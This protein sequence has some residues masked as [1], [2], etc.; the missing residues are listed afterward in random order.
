VRGACIEPPC[1]VQNSLHVVPQ[2]TAKCSLYQEHCIQRLLVFALL[3]LP[4]LRASRRAASRMTLSRF[5]GYIGGIL[6]SGSLS[7]VVIR[8]DGRLLFQW[9][10]RCCG[11][12]LM[13]IFSRF[14]MFSPR[15]PGSADIRGTAI[16]ESDHCGMSY[17]NF[18]RT[19]REQE[20]DRYPRAAGEIAR[21]ENRSHFTTIRGCLIRF[22]YSVDTC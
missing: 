1:L 2:S 8:T 13:K 17:R 20:L 15:L 11:E 7:E 5:H 22:Q 3:R 21:I 16:P 19:N 12:F 10:G 9:N 18:H 4:A 14:S 6:K